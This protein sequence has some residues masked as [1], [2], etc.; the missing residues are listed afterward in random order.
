MQSGTPS[1]CKAA[2]INSAPVQSLTSVSNDGA[3]VLRATNDIAGDFP[4]SI[5]SSGA[6]SPRLEKLQHSSVHAL[7]C[8]F[9]V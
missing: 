8:T 5:L 4:A 9:L 2:P 1:C 3:V 7:L 6:N